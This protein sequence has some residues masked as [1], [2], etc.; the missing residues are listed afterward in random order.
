MIG[1]YLIGTNYDTTSHSVAFWT[2]FL[3]VACVAFVALMG[4]FLYAVAR[5]SEATTPTVFKA[6]LA[7]PSPAR[8]V[9]PLT[10]GGG[11]LP[12]A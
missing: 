6:P 12:A 8:P 11:A 4:T 1:T 10:H 5:A 3:I 9:A 7:P 2:V